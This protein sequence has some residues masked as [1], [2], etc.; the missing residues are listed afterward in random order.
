MG[1]FICIGLLQI[2]IKPKQLKD[3][4][5]MYYNKKE[6]RVIVVGILEYNIWTHTRI[7][8]GIDL[9]LEP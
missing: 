6:Q 8:V 9:Y 4:K 2:S 5:E 7:H 3:F 1:R